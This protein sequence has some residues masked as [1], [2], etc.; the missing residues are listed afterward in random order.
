MK[1]ITG[2]T[3]LARLLGY[4]VIV[5]LVLMPFH[6]V[7]TTWLASHFN[8]FDLLRIWKDLLLVPLGLGALWLIYR[9]HQQDKFSKLRPLIGLIIGYAALE[10]VLGIWALKVHH[11]NANA[12]IYGWLN[13]L[14]YLV[15]FVIA[16]LVAAK[17]NLKKE[18]QRLLLMPASLVVLFGLLQHYVL[19]ADFL[20]H[21]GYGPHTL[22]VYE[23]VDQKSTY[24]RL[25]STL[26]GPNPLGAY[27]LLIVTALVSLFMNL[28]KRRVLVTIFLLASLVVLFFSYSR[29]AWIGALLAVCVF[30]GLSFHS[31]YKRRILLFGAAGLLVVGAS[32]VLLLRHNDR[33]E[34]IFFHTDEHSQSSESSNQKRGSALEDGLRDIWHEPLGRGVGTAGPAS[35]RNNHP[36]RLA[37][38]YYIQIGQE[39]GVFGLLLFLIINGYIFVY[40]WQQRDDT[41]SAVL[42]ASFVGISFVNLLSHAWADD[43]L[44][45]IWW[46]LAGIALAPVILNTNKH[47]QYEKTKKAA[48]T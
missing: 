12:L 21:F 17:T 35:V 28:K 19:P 29:S 5:I 26:R 4:G 32:A 40:L 2:Q 33:A 47:K 27:L 30:L 15:F 3:K 39:L 48:T 7:L 31:K 45:L 1:H 36:T 16:L 25:Q 38:N 9:E 11:V 24:I 34:N 42:L 37:E 44:S 6:A 43:T 18:W 22:P 8:H 20:R 23:T 13:D 41:L 46:G 14:Q 10:L